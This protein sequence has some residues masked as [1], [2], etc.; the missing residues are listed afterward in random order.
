MKLLEYEGKQIF[1]KYGIPIPTSILISDVKGIEGKIAKLKSKEL[2]VKAQIAT[3]GRK[4]L[5]AIKE[6]N[7]SSVRK[8]A[9]SLLGKSFSGEKVQSVLVEEKIGY[10]KEL[11][12]SLAIN[13]AQK[14]ITL[15]VSGDGGIGVEALPHD[16]IIAIP[17]LD[18]GRQYLFKMLQRFSYRDKAMPIIE[19]LYRIMKD[20][21]AEL[22]EINPLH[23]TKCGLVASDAKI[24]LDDNA[25][26]RHPEFQQ[27]RFRG[28]TE[29]ERQAAESG[30]QYV[31]LGGD[32]AV[33]GNGAGLVM[34]TLDSLNYYGG[35]AAN[36]LDIGGGASS[37]RME[38]ALGIA[39]QRKPGKLLINIFGGITRCD[40]IAEAIADYRKRKGIRIPMVVRMIGTNEDK[41]RP[42]LESGGIHSVDS[43]EAGIR[44]ILSL[45]LR[46]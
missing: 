10:Q 31:E 29:L 28:L 24:I 37:E 2:V 23:V 32:I 35:K 5:G 39:L 27:G 21:D 34:A 33:I 11:F 4:K 20:Y 38:K 13:R 36:F 1:R 18:P 30:L 7:N 46:R 12:V 16:K 3:A 17:L 44:K 22:V 14:G 41:A 42:I 25:L 26:Y 19:A 43:M 15:L 6:A 9:E 40:E 8:V 45:P